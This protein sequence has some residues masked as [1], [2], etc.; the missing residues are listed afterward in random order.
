VARAL[1][2]GD[3]TVTVSALQDRLAEVRRA[4]QAAGLLT[5]DPVTARPLPVD[6]LA[7]LARFISAET[8][9]GARHGDVYLAEIVG[10]PGEDRLASWY[11]DSGESGL[12]HDEITREVL[13]VVIEGRGVASVL[14]HRG[15]TIGTITDGELVPAPGHPTPEWFTGTWALQSI[16][17]V[18]PPERPPGRADVVRQQQ[19]GVAGRPHR[20]DEVRRPRDRLGL[21]HQHTVHVTQ[22][23][24]AGRSLAMAAGDS[25]RCVRGHPVRQGPVVVRRATPAAGAACGA[26]GTGCGHWWLERGSPGPGARVRCSGSGG[27]QDDGHGAGGEAQQGQQHPGHGPAARSGSRGGMA[28]PPD[29]G[30]AGPRGA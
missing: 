23:G 8:T 10:N 19:E 16:D 18:Q 17:P 25:I 27:E 24:R 29:Q 3:V 7:D 21:V 14:D 4:V 6:A 9:A 28:G 30:G 15:V 20:G 1:G 5:A 22:P 12:V 11:A 2:G 26:G 13:I